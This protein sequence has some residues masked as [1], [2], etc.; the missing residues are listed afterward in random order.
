MK[1]YCFYLLLVVFVA[2]S[3]SQSRNQIMAD[4]LYS[5]GNYAEAINMYSKVGDER[6]SL[7]IARAYNASGNYEKAITQYLSVIK[8][9]SE[10][11]LS[12]FELG[13]LY[14]KTKKWDVAYVLFKELTESKEANPE[15]YYYLGKVY[16]KKTDFDEAIEVL[17][18]AIEMDNTHL[19]SIYLLGKHYVQVEE[20]SNAVE[21]IN[22]GLNVAPNDVAL[23]NLK[24]LAHFNNGFYDKSAPLFKKLLE[25]GEE[26]PFVFKKL[27]YSHFKNLDLEKAKEAYKSLSAIPNYKADA[28]YGMSEVFM[29]EQQLDSAEIYMKKS[30][31]ERRYIYDE[32]YKTLGRIARLKNQLKKALDYYTKAWEENKANFIN[33]YQVCILADEY[34]K[35]P[36]TRLGYYEKLLTDFKNVSPFISERVKKR[37]SELKEEIHYKSD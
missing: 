25:L 18:K 31:A 1:E 21:I 14:D 34:Y 20:P 3:R 35:D 15:F 7:Q 5:L 29:E 17:N 28:Y 11:V 24:A 19:R 30:I 23:L 4:S 9:N 36:K 12:K 13:K 10:N 6:S 37:I 27:G 2:E 32:E 26:K 8:N 22:L 33:Y 16:L